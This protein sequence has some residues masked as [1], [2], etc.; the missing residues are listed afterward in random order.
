[1]KKK[2][3]QFN[4]KTATV[5]LIFML[6]TIMW[7]T[8]N[9]VWCLHDGH[10]ANLIIPVLF[11]V[12]ACPSLPAGTFRRRGRRNVLQRISQETSQACRGCEEI[13][14]M[15]VSSERP[16]RSFLRPVNQGRGVSLG[17]SRSGEGKYAG[18]R[19]RLR[20]VSVVGAES[21]GCA[22][23]TRRCSEK[24]YDASDKRPKRASAPGGAGR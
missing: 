19:M 16:V 17:E 18:R 6:A 2:N 9:V 5:A 20:A 12:A 15:I 3:A 13:P 14:L 10:Y 23:C 7:L 22:S 21:N 11:V 4:K 8:I 24:G 1:M